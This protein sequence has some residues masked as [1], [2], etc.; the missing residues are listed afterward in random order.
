METPFVSIQTEEESTALRVQLPDE[1]IVLATYSVNLDLDDAEE[2]IIVAKHREDPSDRIRLLIADFDPLRNTYR[3]TWEGETYATGVRSFSVHTQDVIGDHQDEIIGVG[4]DNEGNQTTN[5][6]RR[7]S[8]GSGSTALSYREI[9]AGFADGSIEI[10]EERR[11]EAY[12]T[13]QSSGQSFPIVAYHRNEESDNP[14]DLLRSEYRW[15]ADQE[16]YVLAATTELA[17]GDVEQEQLR[18]LY[19]ADAA[20]MEAFLQGPW[21]RSTGENASPGVELA[22]FDPDGEELILFHGDAQ[23]RYQWLNSYKTIY[24]G[25]PG[26]WVN[27][28]NQVLR[29][30]RKQLS[31]TVLGL[32]SIRI[33]VDGAEYW[34]G[35]YQR[36]TQGI[37]ESVIRRH[38]IGRPDFTL[39]GVYRNE[40]DEE[41]LFEEPYFRFRAAEF[42]WSGGY[43]VIALSKPV[44][45]M[46]VVDARGS[47]PSSDIPRSV[48]VQ[49]GSFNVRF[50][51]DYSEQHSEDRIVRRLALQPARVTVDG[52]EPTGDD[53]I[54]LEQVEDFL[55]SE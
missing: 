39:Q 7:R 26:L 42:D 37:Q 5:V 45:E 6:F 27:L 40:N 32:D 29:T 20:T 8:T 46:K 9:F 34:N 21:F 44:L 35:R 33:S 1:Y 31:V 55:I 38:E 51:L 48:P 22:L 52:I 2:Q 14:L 50:L 43:N 16:R 12:R 49:N 41:L 47:A 13:L 23:E 24:G 53:R 36:M 11:S 4:I 17:G 10:V 25:G 28:R 15:S 30:V 19:D 54:V 18:A 3:V